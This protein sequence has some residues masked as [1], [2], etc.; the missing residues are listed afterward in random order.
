MTR[1]PSCLVLRPGLDEQFLD[2]SRVDRERRDRVELLVLLQDSVPRVGVVQGQLAGE[3]PGELWFL[4]GEQ[5]E[6]DG[7]ARS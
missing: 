1:S 4:Q 6:Q 3:V 5:R 2:E 7:V